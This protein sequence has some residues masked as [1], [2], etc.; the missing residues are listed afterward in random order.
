MFNF[1]K[2]SKN[3][4]EIDGE[5]Y[6]KISLKKKLDIHFILDN[7]GSMRSVLQ[8]TISGFN[9]YLDGLR[10]DKNE[11]RM[12]LVKFGN[13][14]Q[15]VYNHKR[16]EDVKELTSKQYSADGG[17]TALYDAVVTTL[18]EARDQ[19]GRH[20][21]VIMTD[22]GEN[23]SHKYAQ[24]DLKQIKEQLE[25][26]GRWTFVFLGSNQDAWATAQ[27]FGF[28][29]QNVSSYNSTRLGT[30]SVMSNLR[31][32]TMMMAQGSADSTKSYFSKDQQKDMEETV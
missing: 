5:I 28:A 22:G 30:R 20:L 16:L 1:K 10:Q 18:K 19:D 29:P 32:S 17:G 24:S 6:Q 7:S 21:V 4:V 23:A 12:S 8:P 13:A 3:Q 14:V 9:E 11:Y 27:D 2:L 15:T 26:T 25:E 31:A